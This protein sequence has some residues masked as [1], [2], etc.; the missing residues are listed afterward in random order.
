VPDFAIAS[1]PV[2]FAAGTDVV[3]EMVERG[4]L[5]GRQVTLHGLDIRRYRGGQVIAEWQYTNAAEVL[6]H[7][8]GAELAWPR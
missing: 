6:R 8:R 5:D 2:H 7:L 1:L 3:S 4:T